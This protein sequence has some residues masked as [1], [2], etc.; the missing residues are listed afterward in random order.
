MFKDFK[1]DLNDL[2]N[3]LKFKINEVKYSCEYI[4]MKE[5]L[6]SAGKKIKSA[7]VDDLKSASNH[8]YDIG[9]KIFSKKRFKSMLS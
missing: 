4:N 9:R 7:V 2:E 8:A 6:T 5:D 3:R 1:K